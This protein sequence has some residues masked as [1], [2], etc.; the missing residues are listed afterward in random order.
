MVWKTNW[1]VEEKQE[2]FKKELVKDFKFKTN[3]NL[4]F[5]KTKKHKDF[6]GVNHIWN[7]GFEF[8]KTD[9]HI[10]VFKNGDLQTQHKTPLKDLKGYQWLCYYITRF[11]KNVEKD[12]IKE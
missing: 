9:F 10:F 11:F 8:T 6:F 4:K 3:N 7:Y 12:I 5:E 2:Q 1:T